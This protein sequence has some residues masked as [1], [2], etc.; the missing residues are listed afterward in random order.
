MKAAN[1]GK[2]PGQKLGVLKTGRRNWNVLAGD[3]EYKTSFFLRFT[4]HNTFARFEQDKFLRYSF[5]IKSLI[6][7]TGIMW[8]LGFLARGGPSLI[9]F[10][11]GAA[12]LA[13]SYFRVTLTSSPRTVRFLYLFA[14]YYLQL[15]L[16]A[17]AEYTTYLVLCNVLTF[18]AGMR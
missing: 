8:I 13:V 11:A 18:V 3:P 12:L 15:A 2:A 16:H 10:I 1:K 17:H 7:V 9:P 14:E 5:A 6:I 4:D